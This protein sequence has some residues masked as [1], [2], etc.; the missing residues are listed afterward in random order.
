MY[1]YMHNLRMTF[2]L[3][4]NLVDKLHKLIH[5]VDYPDNIVLNHGKKTPVNEQL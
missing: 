3:P 2:I 4:P 1:L 5:L